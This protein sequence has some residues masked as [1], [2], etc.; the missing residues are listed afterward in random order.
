MWS[1]FQDEATR[2][3]TQYH[4]IRMFTNKKDSVIFKLCKTLVVQE[5]EAVGLRMQLKALERENVA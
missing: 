2:V 3:A 1:R 4:E 5:R